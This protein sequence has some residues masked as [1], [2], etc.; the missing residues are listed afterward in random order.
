VGEILS[1]EKVPGTDKLLKIEINLGQRKRTMVAGVANT[2]APEEMV[3]RSSSSSATCSRPSSG[4]RSQA[5][6]L[7]AVSDDKAVIPFFDR[8]VPAGARLNRR[9]RSQPRALPR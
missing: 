2:Y 9:A 4:D 5:M 3:G 1:A 6:L 7:A 8:D